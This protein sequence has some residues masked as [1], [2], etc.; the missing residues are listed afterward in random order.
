M[1]YKIYQIV[2]DSA[3]ELALEARIFT[4]RRIPAYYDSIIKGDATKGLELGMYKHVADIEA[5]DLDSV[6][7]IGNIGPE[8]AITRYESMHSLSVGDIIENSQGNQYVVA[9]FGFDEI[10]A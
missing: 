1:K 5:D 3:L 4:D 9:R 7:E 8:S 2:M 6:F 10:A